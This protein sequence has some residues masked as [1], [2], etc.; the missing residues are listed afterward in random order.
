MTG[1]VDSSRRYL[2]EYGFLERKP[3]GSQYW[4]KGNPVEKEGKN[5]DRKKE[6]KQQYKEVKTQAGIY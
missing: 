3:D 5:M 4:L 6:L 2:I 1:V